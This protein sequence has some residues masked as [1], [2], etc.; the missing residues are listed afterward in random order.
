MI[1]TKR[2]YQVYDL[3]AW[4]IDVFRGDNE[5]LVIAEI[6]GTE[7]R[8]VQQPTWAIE[9]VSSQEKYNNEE[10]AR[11]PYARWKPGTN[12]NDELWSNA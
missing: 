6:E 10:L 12:D 11:H 9:E 8:S 1:V 3:E 5:G 4:D 7:S 2:R